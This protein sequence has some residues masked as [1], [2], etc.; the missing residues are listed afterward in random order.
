MPESLKEQVAQEIEDA[1]D[2]II[3]HVDL[4]VAQEYTY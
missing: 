3:Q 1:E 2:S 4:V